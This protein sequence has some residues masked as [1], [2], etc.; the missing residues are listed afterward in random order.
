MVRA[1]GAQT[2]G[3]NRYTFDGSRIGLQNRDQIKGLNTAKNV[4]GYLT[5]FRGVGGFNRDREGRES[6][7]S[8]VWLS[9]G[10][11]TR[12]LRVNPECVSNGCQ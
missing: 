2:D 1:Q 5:G 7:K 6:K 11:A 10:V 12:S 9:L 3:A 4:R 8:A